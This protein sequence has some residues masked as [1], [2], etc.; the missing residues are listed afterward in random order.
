[1]KEYASIILI[2]VASALSNT[3]W[4][5]SGGERQLQLEEVLVTAQK[6]TESLSP[7]ACPVNVEHRRDAKVY[8][9]NPMRAIR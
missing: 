3:A 5:Q 9:L 6:R 7:L 1:M 8:Q 4:S 2:L